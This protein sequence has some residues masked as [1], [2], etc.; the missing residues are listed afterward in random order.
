MDDWL[1]RVISKRLRNAQR[2]AGE[3]GELKEIWEGAYVALGRAPSVTIIGYSMPPDD[4]EIR[5]LLRADVVRGPKNSS[6]TVRNPSPDAQVR[7]RTWVSKQ[8][9]SDY[10]PF[11]A[12]G[13]A[14]SSSS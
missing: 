1:I 10:G 4:T 8:A 5:T 11:S 6:V 12:F 3:L 2:K 7:L 14:T 13:K 9:K